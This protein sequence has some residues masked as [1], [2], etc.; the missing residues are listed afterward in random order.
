MHVKFGETIFRE[1]SAGDLLFMQDSGKIDI[2]AAGKK[3]RTLRESE[4]TGEHAAFY[5]DKPYNVTA[6]CVSKDGC[7]VQILD[8][9]KIREMCDKNKDLYDSF[10]DIVLRRDFK[11]A[12]VKATRREFPETAEELRAAFS[13]VAARGSPAASSRSGA[14]AT[15][16]N[17]PP[18]AAESAFE[19]SH[20]MLSLLE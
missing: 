17:T 12:L 4:M 11:K 6:Q 13:T 20:I 15:D 9:K 16:A 2:T 18:F 1:G 14:R 5:A 8:G 7:T 3:V 19:P 10:R